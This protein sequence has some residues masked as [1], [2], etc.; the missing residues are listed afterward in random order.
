M[1]LMSAA[2]A[3]P[4]ISPTRRPRSV[5]VPDPVAVPA[6]MPGGDGGTG[7]PGAP[8]APGPV[9]PARPALRVTELHVRELRVSRGAQLAEAGARPPGPAAQVAGPGSRLPGPL[10][11]RPAPAARPVRL[12]RRGRAVVTVAIRAGG[13][14]RRDAALAGHRRGSAGIQ[15]WPAGQRRAARHDQVVVRPGQTL[16]SI[17]SAAEPS[18]NTQTVVQQIIEANALGGGTI[19]AGQL[20]WVP[21]A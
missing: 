2:P 15:P 8:G 12:T 1:S 19:H 20:L 10:A 14:C 9:P 6:G 4:A 13:V 17:A 11:S 5:P 3:S 18:A 21:A 7:R 16:W